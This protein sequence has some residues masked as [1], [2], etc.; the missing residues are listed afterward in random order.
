MP[1]NTIFMLIFGL[2]MIIQIIFQTSVIFFVLWMTLFHERWKN[3]REYIER[4]YTSDTMLLI[5]GLIIFI[6]YF[7]IIF[8]RSWYWNF[9][10]N[11]KWSWLVIKFIISFIIW[12]KMVQWKSIWSSSTSSKSNRLLYSKYF[13]GKQNDDLQISYEKNI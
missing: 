11:K 8:G 12:N 9:I 3:V 5:S 7:F 13:F 10:S 1:P 2:K 6:S 4:S